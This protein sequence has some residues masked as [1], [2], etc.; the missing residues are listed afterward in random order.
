MSQ[1]RITEVS[2]PPEYASATFFT[3]CSMRRIPPVR[4][5]SR[6][7]IPPLRR[8]VRRDLFLARASGRGALPLAE[9]LEDDALLRVKTILRLIED[10]A[11]RS[12]HGGIGDLF[13]TVS[14]QT[15]HDE[16]PWR[17]EAEESLVD[18]V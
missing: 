17:R 2:R 12:V 11:P 1:R 15:V 16:R 10:H 13:P 7:T 9:Q 4:R 14:R 18:L 5:L 3:F 8:P 6:P